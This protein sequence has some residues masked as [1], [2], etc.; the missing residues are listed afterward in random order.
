MRELLQE[1]LKNGDWVG[2]K[3]KRKRQKR[4]LV[5]RTSCL[6]SLWLLLIRQSPLGRV[7]CLDNR[8]TY[9]PLSLGQ[10]AQ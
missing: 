10:R 8:T 3:R 7:V 6:G 4:D 5:L 2:Y 1:Q 9:V